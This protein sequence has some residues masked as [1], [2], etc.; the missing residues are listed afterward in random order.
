MN[1]LEGQRAFARRWSDAA[2]LFRGLAENVE[3]CVFVLD[4]AGRCLAAN[5]AFC[6]WLNRPRTEIVGRAAADFWPYAAGQREAAEHQQVLQGERIERVE[7]PAGLHASMLRLRKAPLRGADGMVRGVLCLF[8]EVPMAML[9]AVP[10]RQ[11]WSPRTSPPA[12]KTILV[13]DPDIHVILLATRILSPEGFYVV[14]ARDGRQALEIYSQKAT[15]I[16][17]VVVE[18]NLPGQSG[19]VVMDELLSINMHLPIVLVSG[20]GWPE[21]LWCMNRPHLGFLS[22]PYTPDQLVRCVRKTL[23]LVR[24]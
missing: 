7:L 19:L 9:T 3:E 17:L 24:A 2:W 15:E 21:P 22:K 16:D 10:P 5:D 23:G 18:Q 14:A 4:V 1:D 13:I 6:R 8:R 11:A 20:S 12:D